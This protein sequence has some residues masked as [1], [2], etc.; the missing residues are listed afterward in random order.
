[1]TNASTTV[2]WP[3]ARAEALA[4][5]KDL[6][7]IDTTNPPGNE[8][9][10]A[11]LCARI[12]AGAGL[13]PTIVESAPG[14][15]SVVARLHGRGVKPPLLLSAHLDVVPA[16][17][18]RWTHPPF[19]AVEA[20]GFVWGRGALDMKNMAAMSLETI[21]LLARHRVPLDRDVIFAGV[22]DEE[23]GSRHGSLFLVER[24]PELVR[25]EFVLTEVGGHTLHVGGERIY[26]IQVSEKGICWFEL[27]AEGE[28][29][30]GSMPSP[31]NAVVR[32]ARAVQ[33]LGSTRL[34]LH[35]T[36]VVEAFVDALAKHSPFPQ[37][38]ILPLLLS[39]TLSSPIVDLVAKADPASARG[40]DA[41]LRNTAT[42]T[43]LAAGRKVN[44]IP[45]SATA[46][47]DGRTIP[48]QSRDA[49]LREVLEA[50]GDDLGVRVIESHDG[51]V[52]DSKTA[53]FETIAAV[54]GA[55]DPGSATVPYMVP[56]FTD[57]FAYAKLGA[58]CYGFAP[59][60][61]PPGVPFTKLFHGH[62]ERISVEGFGWGLEVLHEVVRRFSAAAGNGPG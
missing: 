47:I 9:P 36:P 18:E 30:H 55:A 38:W 60:R 51:T 22:A 17:P 29:G 3:A 41:M 16:E 28:P 2:D 45:S 4:I 15:A 53:L 44:V 37:G 21:V 20:D 13:E 14:R 6:I 54:L 57:A 8:R 31:K 32:L 49:F 11:D 61:M 24:H 52:F 58:I 23:A 40:L 12:L 25:A 33:A 34:P 26:P 62:D 43:A 48:G 10:A 39:P 50:I 56:G 46:T 19:A 1:M 59:L 7:R 35:P 27:T 5:L 42:P